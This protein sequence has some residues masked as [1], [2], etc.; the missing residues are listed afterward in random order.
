[1]LFKNSTILAAVIS[2]GKMRFYFHSI[3]IGLM[4]LLPTL[5]KAQFY[6]GSN[7]EFGKNRV[8]YKDFTWFY[9][10]GEHFD[11]YYYIG[12][13][14]L[15]Q[16]VLMSSEKNLQ[17]VETFF[18]Y[19]I[20]DRLQV[21]SYLNQREFRQSNIGITGED[22]YNIGGAA[23]IIGNKMFTYFEGDHHRLDVQIKESLSRVVF[24]QLMYGGDWK[25][26]IK[27]SALLS[28]PYWYQ[29]GMIAFAAQGRT[30]ESETYVKDLMRFGKFKSFNHF[31]GREARLLGQAFWSYI[32]EVYGSS[33]LPNILY[34]AQAGRNIDSGFLYILGMS[35]E[36]LSADF[37]TFYQERNANSREDIPLETRAP[38]RA[39][40]QAFKQ[41][42]KEQKYMGDLRVKYKK[43]YRY[44]QFKQS[45]DGNKM[46]FVTNEL[47]QYRIWIYDFNTKKKK[48]ILKRDHRLDRVVDDTFPILTWHPSGETLTYIFEKRNTAWLGHYSLEE[49][50]H[51]QKELF[52]IEKVLDIQYS[53]DG[54]KIAMSAANRGQSDIF[55]YQVIGNNQEQLTNDIWDDLHPRFVDNDTLWT[56]IRVSFSPLTERTIRCAPK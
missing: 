20:E 43:K 31:E 34:M 42:K 32:D 23:K 47:G 24:N 5:V 37:V 17:Q 52:L 26:V 16:Y 36:E 18:N 8:Q 40:K 7:M 30:N 13:E 46:A 10:P 33:V 12:G 6:Q 14:K 49:K 15:A 54:K 29:E 21:L 1:M 50:K 51:Q 53:K 41:W 28:V 3:F 11:V 45:P 4:L 48:C 19:K 39:D 22:Q 27:S 38:D 55:L 25:D 9:Y 56:M 2:K 44:S 35:L